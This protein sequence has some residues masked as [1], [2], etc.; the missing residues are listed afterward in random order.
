MVVHFDRELTY[1]C[2]QNQTA[3]LAIAKSEAMN[4]LQKQHDLLEIGQLAQCRA[5]RYQLLK[6]VPASAAVTAASEA[7]TE[8]IAAARAAECTTNAVLTHC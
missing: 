5:G 6:H 4:F 1:S 8:A 7:I 2:Q 3:A